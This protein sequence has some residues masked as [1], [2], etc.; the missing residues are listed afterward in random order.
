MIRVL[1]VIMIWVVSE[2]CGWLRVY[3]IPSDTSTVDLKIGNRYLSTDSV[4]RSTSIR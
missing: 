1:P 4:Q 3:V 2:C